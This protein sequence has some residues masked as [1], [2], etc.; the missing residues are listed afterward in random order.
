M[1][2]QVTVY[3]T[4]WCEVT[5]EFR[6]Y[7]TRQQIDFTFRNVENNADDKAAAMT[8]NNGEYQTPVIQVGERNM[9]NPSRGVLERELKKQGVL[10]GE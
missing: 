7:L 3:G 9:R 6:I 4:A 1:E 2:P 10:E 8:M 5:R